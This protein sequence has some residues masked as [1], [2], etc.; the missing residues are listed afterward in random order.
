MHELI[1]GGTKSGKSSH[2]QAR[3]Q[4]WLRTPGAQAL[5]IATA[6]PLDAQMQ[7]RI[8]RHQQ[9]R[10]EHMPALSV[11]EEPYHLAQAITQHSAPQRLLLVDC[12]TLWLTQWFMPA[13]AC[14]GQIDAV[15]AQQQ[16]ALLLQAL[17][18]AKGP[19]VMV[20]NEISLGVMP[21]S[22]EMRVFM[23]VLG[24]LHQDVGRLCSSVTLMVA[25]IAWPVK[26][27]E[28]AS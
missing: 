16:P 23:D 24:S 27:P 20:S 26:R 14:S 18:Q 6:L 22:A 10:V 9:E 2:A 25:G 5:L 8:Q 28:A 7:A 3:A 17:K 12:L 13:P 15:Q 1:L 4:D 11:V 21:L 19:V